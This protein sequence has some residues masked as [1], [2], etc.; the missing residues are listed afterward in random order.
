MFVTI[1]GAEAGKPMHDAFVVR[2]EKMR[3]VT[4]DPNAIRSDLIIG[5]AGE[6]RTS[7]NDANCVSML[8]QGA[9]VDCPCK[10]GSHHQHS[11]LL[12]KATLQSS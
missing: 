5:V 3:A 12:Q 10:T 7:I 1:E 11:L 2:V 4:M 6:V 9:G 8:S